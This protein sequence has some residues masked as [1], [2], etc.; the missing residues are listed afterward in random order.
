MNFILEKD[1]TI[2][3]TERLT[4]MFI[5]NFDIFYDAVGDVADIMMMHKNMGNQNGPMI[6]PKA[7]SE[8][9]FPYFKKYVR[10]V[11]EKSDYFVT[12][13][14]CGSIYE[15]IP[16]LID[17]GVDILNPVQFTAKD[18]EPEKLKKEVGKDICFWGGGVD[19]QHVLSY[20]SEEEI[21]KQV[22][23]NARV[24]S[25]GGRYVFTP[26]HCIQAKVPT[27]NIIAAFDEVNNFNL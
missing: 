4:D 25:K 24:F 10:H 17:Y 22:R 14:N 1:L 27:G 6:S 8:I 20:G 5:R 26:V 13:H 7:A 11:K 21:G 12:M 23:E 3:F 19:T 9:F 16:G 15:F 18:M 2:Y